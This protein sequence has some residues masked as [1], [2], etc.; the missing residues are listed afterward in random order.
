MAD[1]IRVESVMRHAQSGGCRAGAVVGCPEL[2]LLAM[3]S[4]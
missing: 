1:G 2:V 4:S 3:T